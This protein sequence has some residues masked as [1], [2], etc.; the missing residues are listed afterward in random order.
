LQTTTHAKINFE[1]KKDIMPPTKQERAQRISENMLRKSEKY[2]N[3]RRGEIRGCIIAFASGFI[4][5][6]AAV[7]VWG[8]YYRMPEWANRRLIDDINT[9]KYLWTTIAFG[10]TN[11]L[12]VGLFDIIKFTK[13]VKPQYKHALWYIAGIACGL[14]A[15]VITNLHG[16]TSNNIN[17]NVG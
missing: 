6:Y 5:S 15:N 12:T 10:I 8:D 3:P 9:S 17:I 11:L 7:Q 4:S 2:E 13:E 16:G 14:T 1:M